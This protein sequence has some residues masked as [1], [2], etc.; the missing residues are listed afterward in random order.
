VGFHPTHNKGLGLLG[1][2]ERVNGLG[3]QF[4]IQSQPGQ[5]T[6]LSTYFQLENNRCKTVQESV[7]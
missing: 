5:G 6:I 4:H 7:A 2:M 3:G 1:M